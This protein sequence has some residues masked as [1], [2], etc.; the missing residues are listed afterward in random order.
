MKITFNILTIFPDM[1]TPLETGIIGRAADNGIIG[2][3]KINIRDFSSNKHMNTDDYP[4]GG[5][6]GMLMTIQPVSDAWKSIEKPGRTIFLSPKGEKLTQQKCIELSELESITLICGRY[7][8]VDERIV[9]SMVDEEISIGDYVI[10]GGET[11]AMIIV[12]A[13]SRMLPGVLGNKTGHINE[14]H[15]DGLLEY[16]QYTRPEVYDDMQVPSVLLSGN[17]AE[18]NK[19]RLAKS[20]AETYLKRPDMLMKRGLDKKEAELL[21]IELPEVRDDIIKF[22]R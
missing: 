9:N 1:F 18:I 21:A 14:S 5:G 11:A 20:L 17:H 8:G 16:P 12:D 15:F 3:N 4:Y 19:Y 7:E 22:I 6:D 13:V 10:S 2:V